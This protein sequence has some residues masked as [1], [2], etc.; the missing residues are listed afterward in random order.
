[1]GTPYEFVIRPLLPRLDPKYCNSAGIKSVELVTPHVPSAISSAS[2]NGPDLNATPV[3]HTEGMGS[4]SGASGDVSFEK[5]WVVQKS[6]VA[7]GSLKKLLEIGYLNAAAIP[8][9]ERVGLLS[10]GGDI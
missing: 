9:N 4:E 3:I 1:M 10:P 7:V 5:Q 6:S 2:T 8:S